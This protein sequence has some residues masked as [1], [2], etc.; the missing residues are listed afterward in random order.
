M[1]KHL[2][3]I[4]LLAALICFASVAS[5]Q[6]SGGIAGGVSTGAVNISNLDT[7]FEGAIEG[8]NL[9]GFEAGA[10][11]QFSIGP[12]YIRP[13]V[14]YNFRTG[15]VSY[16]SQQTHQTSDFSIHKFEAP[17]FIGLKIIGPLSIEAAPVYNY[18]ISVTEQY[19]NNNVQISRSGLGYRAGIALDMKSIFINLNYQGVTYD[20]AENH[21][22]FKEPYKITLGIGIRLGG[23]VDN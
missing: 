7:T 20:L 21:A 9:I 19:G 13:Q 12:L 14:M 16:N 5:A 15:E 6:V 18:L 4:I 2:R 22:R 3:Y 23:S 8:S 10:F 17:V 11:L 1:K